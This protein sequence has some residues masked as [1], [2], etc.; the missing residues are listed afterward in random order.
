MDFLYGS[1]TASNI[2]SREGGQQPDLS[3]EDVKFP[4]GD[5]DAFQ[6]V[7]RDGTLQSIFFFIYSLCGIPFSSSQKISLFL[8]VW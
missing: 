6:K 5:S 2:C 3:L 8:L 1:H 7:F 4:P